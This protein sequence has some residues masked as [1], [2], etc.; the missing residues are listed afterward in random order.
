MSI[1]QLKGCHTFGFLS[2]FL[3]I[4]KS[5]MN[6]AI[7]LST[8][9]RALL[10]QMHVRMLMLTVVPFLLSLIVWGVLLWMGLTPAMDWVGGYVAGWIGAD[11]VPTTTGW[12]GSEWLQAALIGMLALWLL[13]PLLIL[14]ALIFVGVFAMPAIAQHVSK[15][16]FPDLVQH[17]GGSFWGSAAMGTFTF[18]IFAALWIATLPLMLVPPLP[19]LVQP[20]LWGWLTYQVMAY[21]ALSDHASA[22]ERQTILRNHRWS[23]LTIG[24]ITGVLSAAPTM[25]WLGGALSVIFLPI[26]AAA[27]IW[28]Y[29]L[30]FV[31]TG[32][33]FEYYCLQALSHLRR[34]S[35]RERLKATNPAQLEHWR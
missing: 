15:R 34:T 21:D 6:S 19:L 23:L 27:S 28:L 32:L 7:L 29:V 20:L 24:V 3:K 22:E 33:W 10:S 31:F 5:R 35:E 18:V 11:T 26:M 25:L 13:L 30:V 16:D 8:F 2:I 14:T 4:H 12:W 1:V 17:H 9:G